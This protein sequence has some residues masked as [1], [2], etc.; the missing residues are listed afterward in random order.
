M[1]MHA[2]ETCNFNHF[3]AKNL[4]KKQLFLRLSRN[5]QITADDSVSTFQQIH[6]Q[7]NNHLRFFRTYNIPLTDYHG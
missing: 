7:V 6:K 1:Y 2:H 4:P 3:I 5:S